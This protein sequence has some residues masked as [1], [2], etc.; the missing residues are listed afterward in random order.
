MPPTTPQPNNKNSVSVPLA[1]IVAGAMIAAAVFFGGSEI[2][3]PGIGNNP[4]SNTDSN[5]NIE[6]VSAEDHILGS[7][8]AEIVIVEYSDLECPFCKVFHNTMHQIVDEYEGKVAWVYR[9]FPIEQLHS[10][11][12]KE[13]EASE[14]AADQG[15]DTIFWK[16]IDTVF[17][18]TNT[19]N[20]LDPAEL[21]KIA[22]ELGL[23]MN[24]FNT[25]LNSGQFT[26][27]I[28][29]DIAKAAEA[30]ARGTPYSII[31]SKSGNQTV[32][33]GAEPIEMVREKI[34]TLLK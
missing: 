34:D 23:D 20:T 1:I 12:I 10:R 16:Y 28:E 29:S 21:P 2:K 13:S 14:C 5:A 19:N 24:R 4:S 27:E 9:H 25:C 33:N 6:P 8:E 18:R 17:T 30:G 26:E 32:I 7:M 11:A 22:S 3:L 15:G 31:I